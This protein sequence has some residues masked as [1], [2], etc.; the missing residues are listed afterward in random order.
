[1]EYFYDYDVAV[2]GAGSSGMN[3]ALY[4]ARSGKSV[5]IIEKGLYGGTLHDTA[6]IENY[7]GVGTISGY[8]LAVNMENQ[9][10]QQEGVYH[11]YGEVTGIEKHDKLFSVS[12]SNRG[13]VF[14]KSVV[15]ATGVKH[16]KLGVE[17]EEEFS[18]RGVSYCAVC[19]GNFFAN[20]SVAV[21]GG[22]NSALDEALYLSNI[23]K[24]VTIIHRRDEF[25]AD[26]VLQDRVSSKDN[27]NKL[28]GYN[29][30]SMV[31]E[32]SLTG[33]KIND[34]NGDI[35]EKPFDGVFIY[36]GVDPVSEPFSKEILDGE[37]YVV[38]NSEMET[39][40]KGLFAVGDIRSD[41][42]R[43]VATAVGDGAIASRSVTEYLRSV[44]SD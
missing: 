4:L 12:L 9:V 29:V 2:I 19:D 25:R 1:M 13:M 27:I 37:G 20:R 28:M 30:K 14:V 11:K 8:D 22:G 31:G 42:I 39:G 16:R 10:R 35:V 36:I 21:I 40:I 44:E 24:T 15:I 33:L 3:T 6:E 34:S 18:G 17:G 7:L 32:S 43:Q 26:K 41:S 23:A 38:T 5:V